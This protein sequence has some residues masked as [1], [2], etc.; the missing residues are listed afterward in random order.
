[1]CGYTRR[2][3]I[4]NEDIQRQ[5]VSDFGGRQDAGSEFEM[6]R[7]CDEEIYVCPSAEV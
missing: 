7:A 2:D 5:G 6:V 4:K 3:R 1:M